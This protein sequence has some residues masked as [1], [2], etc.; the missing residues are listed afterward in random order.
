M[1]AGSALSASARVIT[2]ARGAVV[3]SAGAVAPVATGA[4]CRTVEHVVTDIATA[5]RLTPGTLFL[6]EWI[7]VVS[8]PFSGVRAMR[9]PFSFD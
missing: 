4:A 5:N 9:A 6:A 7:M 8:K 2:R 3:E 1:P